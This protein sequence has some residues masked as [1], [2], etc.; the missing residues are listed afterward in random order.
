MSDKF[1]CPSNKDG[2]LC[3][4]W[5]LWKLRLNNGCIG[6]SNLDQIRRNG[7][8]FF[9]LMKQAQN[10]LAIS[11]NLSLICM[12]NIKKRAIEG[13]KGSDK[14]AHLYIL[15]LLMQQASFQYNCNINDSIILL[16]VSIARLNDD[17]ASQI[18]AQLR[19]IYLCF[20]DKIIH[21]SRNTW[22]FSLLFILHF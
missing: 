19:N 13:L 8:W 4:I 16:L 6:F 12:W 21:Y 5:E 11:M 2:S 20:T 14:F 10:L 9:F 7:H 15:A 3:H 1:S 22:I 17:D 18:T